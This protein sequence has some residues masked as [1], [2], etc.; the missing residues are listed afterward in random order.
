MPMTLAALNINCAEPNGD[1]TVTVS[2]GGQ[3]MTLVDDGMRGRP[4]GGRRHLFGAVHAAG[5]GTYTMTF[6]N[7]DVVTVAFLAHLHVVADGVRL[8]ND[9]RHQPEPARDD[10]GG[11]HA[12][13]P[14]PV[15]RARLHDTVRRQQR[16]PQRR[17]AVLKG[18]STMCPFRR[19]GSTRSWRRSGTTSANPD[20]GST[21]RLLGRDRR[22]A[23]P[24]ARRRVARHGARL[25]SGAS[26]TFQT[27]FFEGSNDVLFNYADTIFGGACA[28][29]DHGRSATVGMQTSREGC[30][31]AQRRLGRTPERHRRVVDHD[32]VGTAVTVGFSSTYEYCFRGQGL[33]PIMVRLTTSD[34]AST[35]GTGLVS[36]ATSMA[37]RG[38]G[39]TQRHE[40]LVDLAG[41]NARR[42]DVDHQHPGAERCT[43]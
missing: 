22:G 5:V 21:E 16:Q 11:D 12:A 39:T 25:L 14:D 33:I 18:T 3:A 42:R 43:L 36:Y 35:A 4:G 1:V 26:V 2:P 24:G 32:A 37:R 38:A 28:S 6:S 23:E 40:R 13:V 17:H 10:V 34:G 20:D 7:G 29:A 31:G 30:D 9:R 19:R 41:R 8:P 27:V 15:R